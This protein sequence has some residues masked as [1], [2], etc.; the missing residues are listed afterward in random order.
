MIVR[1]VATLLVSC[2][3]ATTVCAAPGAARYRLDISGELRVFSETAIDRRQKD[4]TLSVSAIGR[5][6]Y[7]WQDGKAKLAIA[8]FA[9]VDSADQ[10]RSHFDLREFELRYRS[11][12][13]DGRVGIGKVFWGTT[14]FVHLVDIINQTDAIESLDGEDKLGQPMLSAAWSARSSVVT[15]FMMP[16]FRERTL[17]GVAGRLRGPVRYQ[18]RGAAFESQRGRQHVDMAVRW[19]YASHGVDAGLAHFVGTARE[20]RFELQLGTT[21]PT[22]LPVYDQIHQSSFDLNVV[23]GSWIWKLEALH[24]HNRMES[25]QA[26]VGGF[27]HTLSNVAANAPEVGI[28]A[29]YAWDGRTA[30]RASPYQDDLFLGL[31]VARNDVA[32]SE[33]LAGFSR[34]LRYHSNSFS[35]DAG[36]RIGSDGRLTLKLR[37]IGNSAVQ[38]PLF[39]LRHDDHAIVEYTRYF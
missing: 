36:R 14:E 21:E 8:P 2:C 25:Y 6:D 28:L 19:S 1:P 27:E 11:D 3:V 15:A 12:A 35:L 18:R 24:Q 31:R 30:A 37:L 34:D 20:P 33:L 13:F 23:R 22:L 38:D 26:A 7:E 17:P 4:A 9:R 16:Y 10:Q 29:E 5:A 39:A 32:G